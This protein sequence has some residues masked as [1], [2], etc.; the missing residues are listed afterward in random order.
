MT[1]KGD[2]IEALV[3]REK[4]PEARAA[5]RA[6]LK[7]T[8]EDHWLLTRLSTTYYEERNYKEALRWAEK[9]RKIAPNC[10]LVLWDYAGVLDMLG[11]KQEAIT[12]YHCLLSRGVDAVAQDE[13][14][15][16]TEWTTALLNDCIYRV[17]QCWEDL[18][19]L[20]RAQSLYHI[21]LDS[22][23]MGVSSIYS[24]QE[25]KRKP[26]R[27]KEKLAKLSA[28]QKKHSF[29]KN[30]RGAEPLVKAS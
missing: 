20:E 24:S 14:G 23:N 9:A 19:E 5:I 8:P 2:H 11:K 25:A 27:L 7:T 13:C 18:K 15:E 26:K 16:G 22:R 12:V 21:Y 29:E 30:L 28:K 4:W 10:P 1:G 17:G 6:E 3:E